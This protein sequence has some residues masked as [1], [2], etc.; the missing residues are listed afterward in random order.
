[1]STENPLLAM[2]GLPP[3]QHIKPEHVQP[4]LEALIKSNREQIETLLKENE[5]Y[6]WDNLIQP[7]EDMDDRLGRMW[8]PVSHM[9]SVVNSDVPPSAQVCCPLNS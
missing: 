6:S 1:M 7:L 5:H 3:F 9:N 8:S 4:A 2:T